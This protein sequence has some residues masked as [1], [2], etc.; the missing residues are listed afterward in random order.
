MNDMMAKL[1]ALIE[2]RR[3]IAGW[4]TRDPKVLATVEVMDGTL[5]EIEGTLDG[6]FSYWVDALHE[7][8]P[9]PPSLVYRHWLIERYRPLA[10]SLAA[11][12]EE[13]LR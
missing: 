7:L 9:V 5:A 13:T 8:D 4:A 12:A 10:P 2:V 6:V 1:G 3:Q 11:L